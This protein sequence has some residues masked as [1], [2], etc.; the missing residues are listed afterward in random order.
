M[1]ARTSYPRSYIAAAQARIDAQ[2]AAFDLVRE[3]NPGF[4]SIFF[5][6]LVIVLDSFFTHRAREIEGSDANP[7]TE[8]RMLVVSMTVGD[9][10]AEDPSIRYKPSSSV[11][12]LPIGAPIAL[13]R[14]AFASLASAFFVEL[15]QRF[16]ADD[17]PL[18]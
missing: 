15:D 4:E 6:N 16:G 7:L 9:T 1:L 5:N 12:G 17:E 8:V 10:L 11:L 3:P 18:H 2:V 14:Q 13:T